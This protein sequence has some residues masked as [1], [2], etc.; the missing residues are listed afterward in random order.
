MSDI[1]TRSSGLISP[2]FAASTPIAIYGLGAVGSWS[3]LVL[4]KMGFPVVG[5]DFDD[6]AEVNLGPQLFSESDVGTSKAVA[7]E[8]NPYMMSPVITHVDRVDKAAPEVQVHIL[9]VDS[10]RFR[11]D[12]MRNI[13]RDC[14]VIDSRMGNVS[15][16]FIALYKDKDTFRWWSEE[17]WFPDSKAETLPARRRRPHGTQPSQGA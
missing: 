1:F 4:S 15:S 14:L 8:M 10:M 16:E 3:A 11:R 7:L 9:A 17:K 6:V 2:D 5:Y 12:I 13:P